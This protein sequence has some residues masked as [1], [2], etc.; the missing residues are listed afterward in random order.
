[1]AT[2]IINALAREM[3]I[4]ILVQSKEIGPIDEKKKPNNKDINQY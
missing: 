1:M 3:Y 4:I 2:F